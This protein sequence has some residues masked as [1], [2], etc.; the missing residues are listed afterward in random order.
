MIGVPELGLCKLCEL[1]DFADG[2]LR[3][4]IRDV[5]ASDRERFGDPDFPA[6]REYRKYWEVAMTLRAFRAFGALRETA[7]ILGVGAGH[8]ATIYW[9]TRHV[10]RVIATDLYERV[11]V[12]S[13]SDSGHEMLT[14]P[15]RYWDGP[16]NPE[17][18]EV[19]H[20]SG[21]DLEFED[22]SFDAIF[23][24]SSI[25]HFGDFTDIRRSVEEM[26]RVLKPGGVAALATEF[27]LEGPGPGEPGLLRFDEPELRSLLLDGLWWDPATPLDTTISDETLA[28][29]VPIEEAMADLEAGRHGWSRYPHIVLRDGAY[30][31]TSVHVAVVKSR[32]TATEWRRRAGRLP[33][34]PTLGRRLEKRVLQPLSRVKARLRRP[35][36]A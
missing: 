6:G 14:D 10:A 1:S 21:L 16:W 7:E 12:W 22:E 32:L 15:G 2:E 24:S 3:D 25:E 33:P 23:S 34:K 26:F 30:L 35:L 8:E 5:Y 9:L 20:M 36:G 29:P 4:L 31:W 11:D 13:E 27:R 18:L 17:R 19:R 28:S